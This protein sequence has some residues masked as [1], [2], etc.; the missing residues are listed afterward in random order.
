MSNRIFA[1]S[2][3]IITINETAQT[4]SK[5]EI[6]LWNGTGSAPVS[7]TYTL[8]KAIP[9]STA[10][11][12]H[13]DVSPYIREYINF[14][15]RPINYNTT[16]ATLGSTAY[17]NVTIKRYKNT[18]T[19]L[20]TTTYYAFDGYAEYSDGYNY[21]RGQYLLDE[22]T[23][24]YHYDSDLTYINTKAGDLTL[25]VTAGQKVVYTNLVTNAVS[26]STFPSSGL[27]TVFRVYGTFWDDGN[28][29][30]I[31][32]SADAVLR[33]YTFRPIEECKYE[34]LPIDFV[35]KYGAWQREFLF[36]ASNDTFNM[37]NQDFN[38]MNASIVSFKEFEGQKKTFNANGR[39]SIKVNT[40]WVAES[41]KNTI[42]E[43]MLSEKIILN[44]LPVTIKTKQIELFKSIN[45]KNINYALEFD[46]SFDTIMSII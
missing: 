4:S 38:I 6:F 2:P 13:Y 20:N 32:T 15:L 30:E 36:K 35:N 31:K 19:L 44:D 11:S 12:T 27:K 14:N 7:P 46:Y 29:L 28:K 39:E 25:E 33:T 18:S 10:P 5:I 16:G 45:T 9:S 1:R 8:S 42:K 40:G 22:G 23:Y 21:D 24:Y 17:C 34:V 41:F 37:T 3:Y 43:I 26:T